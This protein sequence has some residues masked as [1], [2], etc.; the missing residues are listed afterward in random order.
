[1][2]V[3][4]KEYIDGKFDYKLSNFWANADNLMPGNGLTVKNYLKA[5]GQSFSSGEGYGFQYSWFVSISLEQ[6]QNWSS[7]M[8]KVYV[9]KEPTV[10]QASWD[11]TWIHLLKIGKLYGSSKSMIAKDAY[12]V[13]KLPLTF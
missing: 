11:G 3:R 5:S 7:G 4:P 2:G 1:V 13:C 8:P 9:P 6:L 12:F 10:D